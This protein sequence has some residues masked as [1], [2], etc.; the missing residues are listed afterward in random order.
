MLPQGW[1]ATSVGISGHALACNASGDSFRV[2][3]LTDGT[4]TSS[5]S[6]HLEVQRNGQLIEY[7]ISCSL[8]NRRELDGE[9]RLIT[10]GWIEALADYVP[11]IFTPAGVAL[12]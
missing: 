2:V 8:S 10:S 1:N 11:L 12:P 4:S 5:Q 9:G 3:N 6:T 7:F